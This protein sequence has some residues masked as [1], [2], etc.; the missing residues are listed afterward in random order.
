MYNSR[1]QVPTGDGMPVE[2]TQGYKVPEIRYISKH[3]GSAN[4]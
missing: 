2:L 1:I 4:K 3:V